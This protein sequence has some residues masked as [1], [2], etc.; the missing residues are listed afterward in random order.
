MYA[1][2]SY[3][4]L[5]VVFVLNALALILFP[6][7]GHLLNMSQEAFGTWSA[8][9]IHDTS[10]VVGA[11]AAYGEEALKIATTVKLTRSLWIIP[12]SL[13]FAL[14]NKQT[15][16]VQFPWFIALFVLAILTGHFVPNL[17]TLY[18]MAN[19]AGHQ[20]MTCTKSV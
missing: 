18:N 16:K 8:I 9:A 10:S 5:I 14:Y 13:T 4:A 15:D 17:K 7:L 19:Y 1:I 2:R 11:G 12:V 6:Y 20:G 3:Y